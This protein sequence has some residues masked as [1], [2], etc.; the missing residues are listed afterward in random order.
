MAGAFLADTLREQARAELQGQMMQDQI[1]RQ[2][3]RQIVGQIA[4][5]EVG[6]SINRMRSRGGTIQ[7][8]A[9]R[10]S[11][12]EAGMTQV[13]MERAQARKAKEMGLI[14]AAAAATGALG[15]YLATQ[16]GYE[17]PKFDA[18]DMELQV[19][20]D[21]AFR[22]KLTEGFG[23]KDPA[24]PDFN[25][26]S[27]TLDTSMKNY[28]GITTDLPP[29]PDTQLALRENYRPLPSEITP[30]KSAPTETV[31]TPVQHKIDADDPL[32]G[33]SPHFISGGGP[34]IPFTESY[35]LDDRMMMLNE[36]DKK[37]MLKF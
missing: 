33:G 2:V 26:G 23:A 29:M 35:T 16:P 17:G 32:D 18:P 28:R 14:T 37:G 34:G 4:Q 6:Q 10:T 3:A 27:T 7:S 15:G 12:R 9:D 30:V 13:E 19:S 31:K 8:A 25:L 24:A 21:D 5:Q 36:L 20:G 22:Q 11:R 1:A